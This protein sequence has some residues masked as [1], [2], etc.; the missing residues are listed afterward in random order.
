M[1]QEQADASRIVTRVRHTVERNFGRLK[2]SFRILDGRIN[3][4]YVENKILS[5]IYRI[6]ASI[7]NAFFVK[8][9]YDSS[10]DALDLRTIQNRNIKAK[11]EFTQLIQR[12]EYKT[13]VLQC[14]VL[15]CE[16]YHFRCWFTIAWLFCCV[17]PCWYCA[18][19]VAPQIACWVLPIITY[20]LYIVD[21]QLNSALNDI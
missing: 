14:I 12:N 10:N 15:L 18:H 13:G 21:Y 9:S 1:T 8:L 16:F 6:I 2:A 3:H 11:K 17:Y 19:Y 4:K 5:Q 20:G 7:S